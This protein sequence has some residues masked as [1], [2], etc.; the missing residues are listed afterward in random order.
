MSLALITEIALSALLLATVIYCAVLERKLSAL[1][2][3]QDG[4]KETIG[5]LNGAIVQASVAMRTLRAAAEEAGKGL[6][7]QVGK[8]RG[9]IDELSLL[10]ASGE[11]IAQR[12]ADGATP[13]PVAGALPAALA[14]R[15]NALRP[16]AMGAIR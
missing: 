7:E 4:L 10:T 16:A 11:R 15:L 14:N 1:R 2:K 8:A 12:I 13:K 3:G 9:M 5:D 6:Q